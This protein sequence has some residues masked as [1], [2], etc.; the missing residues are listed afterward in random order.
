MAL[1]AYNY[2]M[3]QHGNVYTRFRYVRNQCLGFSA[4][5]CFC[6]GYAWLVVAI[7]VEMTRP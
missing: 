2:E 5:A 1:L 4:L 3:F 6:A 7:I